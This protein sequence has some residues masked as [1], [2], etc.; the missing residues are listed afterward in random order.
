MRHEWWVT[1]V[2]VSLL[3]GG[4]LFMWFRDINSG[5][6]FNGHNAYD[7][8]DVDKNVDSDVDKENNDEDS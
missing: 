7:D 2:L 1:A 5:L 6:F 4:I 8:P 3:A